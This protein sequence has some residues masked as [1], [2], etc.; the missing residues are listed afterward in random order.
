MYHLVDYR[1][2]VSDA[3][4][5]DAYARA[6]AA[7]V[8][9]GD[10]VL[11]LGCGVGIFAVLAAKAG[12]KKVYAVDVDDCVHYARRVVDHNGVG[13]RVEIVRGRIEEVV[14]PER[15]D[16]VIG[17]VRG[18]LPLDAGGR[19]AWQ[20][21]RRHL[22]PGA[23]TVPRRDVVYA[24]P[25]ASETVFREQHQSAP[26]GGVAL[27]S[28]APSL[29]HERREEPDDVVPLADAQPLF[30]IDY[31]A[32][33]PAR[34]TGRATFVVDR[35]TVLDA[36]RLGF[37]ADLAPG[38]SYRS[39]GPGRARAYGV[40]VVPTPGRRLLEAGAQVTVHLTI[41]AGDTECALS[42]AVDV[43]RAHGAWQGELVETGQSLDVVQAGL[44]SHVPAPDPADDL[45]AFVLEAFRAGQSVGEATRRATA[46]FADRRPPAAIEARVVDLAR[47]RQARTVRRIPHR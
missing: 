25:V 3:V 27:S 31:G 20:G 17:D 43:D 29:A 13:D 1:T 28:L 14:F 36:I 47:R 45:D 21:A 7:T 11:D 24:Q 34:F 4:R 33:L 44:A 37:Q 42:W 32:E 2:M 10:V 22:A 46:A 35:P 16:V 23:R 40:H 26:A 12:A 5:V 18:P 41:D 38:V 8:R 30:E 39:F 6:I 19:A 9:P 15:I